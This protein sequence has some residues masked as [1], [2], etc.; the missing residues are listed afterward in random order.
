MVPSKE[1]RQLEELET[2]LAPFIELARSR[3]P[4]METKDALA[5]FRE[6]LTLREE[7]AIVRRLAEPP[8]L[9]FQSASLVPSNNSYELMFQFK[10]SKDVP[11]GT[12]V[13]KAALPADSP[14][15]I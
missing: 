11:L 2:K 13:F 14:A 1:S 15:R 3:F 6:E 5:R 4:D 7:L 8:Q 10:S 9:I 12:L